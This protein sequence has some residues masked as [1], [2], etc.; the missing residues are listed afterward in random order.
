MVHLLLAF[1]VA[2]VLWRLMATPAHALG[3]MTLAFSIL[4]GLLSATAREYR[5]LPPDQRLT[6]LVVRSKPPRRR[7]HERI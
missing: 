3:P 5:Q 2:V 4:L 6:G 1:A 7:E